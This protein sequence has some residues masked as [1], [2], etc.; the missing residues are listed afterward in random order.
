FRWVDCLLRILQTCIAPDDVRAALKKL[1][2]DLDSVYTRILESID[3]MQ[4]VYIQRAMH[5]LTFSVEPLTLSQLAEAVRIEYDV[6]KYGED[7]KPLFNMSSLMSICPS[8][9]SFEDA[10][11]GQSASQE[12]RRLRLA[13]FSVK[14]YLI[15]ERAA[16]G[17]GAY[18][19][20]SEDKA[21]FLMGH[22]CLSRIL[23]HN[24]P[25][26][27][28]EGKVEET[29]FLYHSSRYWF[30]Y[31]GSIEDTAPTQLSNAALKVLEL[32]K[33]WLDVYDPDCPYR[34]PL[35]LPGSR[36][37]PPALY[38]SSLLNLVT[39][40]KLLVSRTE[41]AVNVNA[42]GGEYGNALQAAA[43][44][45]NESVARVLLEHGAEV[46][47]QGGACGNALQAAA[48]GGNE[49]VV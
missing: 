27:V 10:R 26:T 4:R 43:I 2:K 47:A 25:A 31:I 42:Q 13:H 16:Q 5:W 44:R 38:Y 23:W 29:S 9:I 48:Y 8:L 39:T 21:N 41:D 18:C 17:P 12:D 35:V 22:A 40:C 14:E 20:I 46:N 15:S 1:P 28:Q 36:V 33:G 49:S 45:G 24:A 37:Y 32:G 30:R 34:D 19:H 7:S 11:N 6:D 3:E